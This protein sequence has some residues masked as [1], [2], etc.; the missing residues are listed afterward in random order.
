M[1]LSNIANTTVAFGLIFSFR[2]DSIVLCDN[3]EPYSSLIAELDLRQ[4]L[5]QCN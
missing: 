2:T 5:R 1:F 4:N 3:T